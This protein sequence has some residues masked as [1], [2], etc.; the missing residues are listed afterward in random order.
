MGAEYFLERIVADQNKKELDQ[1][2]SK[3]I[4]VKSLVG[5]A[6]LALECGSTDAA[7]ELLRETR[8]QLK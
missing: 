2:R 3:M 1:L 6:L 8:D 7:L 4:T 5:A